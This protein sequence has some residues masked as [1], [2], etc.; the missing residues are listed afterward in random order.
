M[1]AP[2]AGPLMRGHGDGLARVEGR[3]RRPRRGTVFGAGGDAAIQDRRRLCWS[4]SGA[5]AGVA[6]GC[7]TGLRTG[8]RRVRCVASAPLPAFC[9][10]GFRPVIVITAAAVASSL[11]HSARCRTPLTGDA[12][13]APGPAAAG[14]ATSA[15]RPR[16]TQRAGAVL[17]R[18]GAD[19]RRA[20]RRRPRRTAA[21]TACGGARPPGHGTSGEPAEHGCRLRRRR[22]PTRRA[23]P[24][25]HPATACHT[26]GLRGARGRCV[27]GRGGP[28]ALR[29][30][31]R[32]LT[33]RR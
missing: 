4:R 23:A 6:A 14:A 18:P 24:R 11:P 5:D 16:A 2:S 21:G 9:R 31:R 15:G 26:R 29:R 28:A 32:L 20:A 25:R 7:T 27:G 19:P 1:A 17:Q 30:A 22:Q 12:P 8:T 10:G 33:G 3:H 13:I